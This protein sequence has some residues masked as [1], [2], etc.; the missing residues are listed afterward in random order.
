[1]C[2]GTGKD[3]MGLSLARIEDDWE[4]VDRIIENIGVKALIFDVLKRDAR[5]E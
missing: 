2:F 1:M 4:A 5:H 3:H